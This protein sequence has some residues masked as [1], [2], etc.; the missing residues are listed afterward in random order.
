MPTH[1]YLLIEPG[2]GTNLSM[3]MQWIKTR[4]TSRWIKIH[5]STDHMLGHRY[6]ARSFI[7]ISYINISKINSFPCII[8]HI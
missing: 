4:S 5:G 7:E 8:L 2:V 6:F 1:I 3:I